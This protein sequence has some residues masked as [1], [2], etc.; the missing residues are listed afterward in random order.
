MSHT[1]A[2]FHTCHLYCHLNQH[3]C[4]NY[5]HIHKVWSR[6]YRHELQN[7]VQVWSELKAY[8][9]T[10]K[11]SSSTYLLE[12]VRFDSSFEDITVVLRCTFCTWNLD[13]QHIADEDECLLVY[14]ILHIGIDPYVVATLL[15]IWHS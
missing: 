2:V 13:S 7:T 10:T 15:P 4:D 1:Y 5:V 9:P 14:N 12:R 6:I 11:I 8:F 3:F